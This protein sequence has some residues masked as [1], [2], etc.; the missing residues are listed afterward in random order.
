MTSQKMQTCT[1]TEYQ[2]LQIVCQILRNISRDNHFSNFRNYSPHKMDNSFASLVKHRSSEC[3][4]K[5]GAATLST[6]SSPSLRSRLSISRRSKRRSV[7]TRAAGIKT[8]CAAVVHL[9][10]FPFA[11]FDRFFSAVCAGGSSK[12]GPIPGYTCSSFTASLFRLASVST[13]TKSQ[14]FRTEHHSQSYT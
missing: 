13:Q 1:S 2:N 7:A 10:L 8:R 12:L 5:A 3:V 9:S 11:L 6:T 4:E 14:M